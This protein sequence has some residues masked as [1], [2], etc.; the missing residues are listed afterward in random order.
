MQPRHDPQRGSIS[1]YDLLENVGEGGMGVVYR[2]RDRTL[3]RIVA[4][5]FLHASSLDSERARE[6]FIHEAQAI[7]RLNHRHIAVIHA[8]EECDNRVFLVFEYLPGGTLRSLLDNLHSRDEKMP[9]QMAATYAFQIADALSHAH[10]VGV[11]HR[12]IK[13]S[14]LMFARDGDLKIVDFGVSRLRGRAPITEPGAVVGTPMYMS[15][16]QAQAKEVD[17]R[18]DIFSLGVVL[19]EMAAGHPPFAS[20][21]LEALLQQIVSTP[22]PRIRTGNASFSPEL[23]RIVCRALEKNPSARYPRMVDLADD[24]RSFCN[25]APARVEQIPTERLPLKKP[26]MI[27]KKWIALAGVLVALALAFLVWGP[28]KKRNPSNAAANQLYQQGV[29]RL[30]RFYVAGNID[31]AIVSFSDAIK[32]A[33]N[34]AEAYAALS[35][36]YRDKYLETRD[37][38]FLDAARTNADRAL[39]IDRNSV[40]G[41]IASAM[42]L[43]ATGDHEGAIIAFHRVLAKDALNVEAM[44]ELAAVYSLKNNVTEAGKFYLKAVQLKPNDW[45]SWSQSGV[46]HFAHQDYERAETDFQ[47][48]IA[49][50]PDSPA[51]HRNLGGVEMALG[52]LSDAEKEFLA[53]ITLRPIPSALSNLGALYIYERRYGD[54]IPILERAIQLPTAGYQKIH[55]VWANL[56]DAYRYTPDRAAQAPQA[57]QQAVQE[58]EKL[59]AFT[60]DDADLLSDASLYMAKLGRRAESLDEIGRALRFANGNSNVSFRAALV[61]ELTG[62]RDRAMAALA[63]AIRGGYSLD[64]IEREPALDKLRQ[65]HRYR[66]MASV[67]PANEGRKDARQ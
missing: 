39:A 42:V 6:R 61:Y 64:E 32:R 23:D 53:S 60:P 41:Q 57:Y 51:A 2:A 7:S 20:D 45:N 65:D 63:E 62:S 28:L 47:H 21:K 66:Q 50:T 46:F 31:K 27:W 15:P 16:E 13:P 5:K 37:R 33:P 10:A 52:K 9:P 59:L 44:R 4:L 19:Y 18:S 12:D 35:K 1:H 26:S 14:N 24:L 17:E 67:S 40:D 58:V 54:A 25:V 38:R 22:V 48:V 3:D 29:D 49:L 11:I 43:E 8:I 30:N 36:A 55:I 34:F 56:G